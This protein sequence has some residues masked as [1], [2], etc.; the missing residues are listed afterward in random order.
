MTDQQPRPGGGGPDPVEEFFAAHRAQVRDEVAD[1]LTWQ[2]IR[3]GRRSTGSARRGA[4]AGVMVAAAAALAVVVG[5]S[6]LPDAREPDLAGPS[7]SVTDPADGPGPTGTDEPVGTPTDDVDTPPEV[8]DVVDPATAD[9]PAPEGGMPD[10]PWFTDITAAPALGDDG[11][12]GIV[13][14]NCAANAFCPVLVASSDGGSTWEARADLLRLGLV[15]RVIFT[16]ADRGWAWGSKAP[17]WSTTDGG[18]SWTAVQI[19][20]NR[21]L[22]LSVRDD[23]VLATVARDVAC[24]GSPCSEPD[25]RAVL[26]GPEDRDWRDDVAADLG[27]GTTAPV[28]ETGGTRYVGVLGADERARTL[29]RLQN[30]VLESTAAASDCGSGPAAVAASWADPDRLVALCDDVRGLAMQQS[31]TGGRTWLATNRT[32][33]SFVLGERAPLMVSVDA[34]H[35]LLVGEGNY[36]VTADDGQTWSAETFLPEALARPERLEVTAAGEIVAFPSFEQGGDGLGAWLSTDGGLTW[37]IV[38]PRG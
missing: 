34:G 9:T 31:D 20:G 23:G 22:D 8:E 3:D 29:F 25:L 27:Q 16:H 24:T 38:N 21:V 13:V 18:A 33:P 30:G 17:L 37:E 32:V 11:R 12:F 2:R 14:E 1:D 7:P 19:P 10:N 28:L 26:A 35:V 15:D 4:W 36:A 5:P 6:L